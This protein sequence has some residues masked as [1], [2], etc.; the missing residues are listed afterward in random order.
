ML[1]NWLRDFEPSRCYFFQFIYSIFLW[2]NYHKLRQTK[3][4]IFFFYYR[5][6]RITFRMEREKIVF[7]VSVHL[8][9]IRLWIHVDIIC[10]EM[11]SIIIPIYQPYNVFMT[12]GRRLRRRRQ[13]RTSLNHWHEFDIISR[14]HLSP[15]CLMSIF[16]RYAFP[17]YLC[18]KK[19]K[20]DKTTLTEFGT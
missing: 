12:R 17:V 16:D 7:K 19:I 8:H 13:C 10:N 4:I 6:G 11:F 14:Q 5:Y 9:D 3:D 1:P 18:D 15:K 2:H 20:L